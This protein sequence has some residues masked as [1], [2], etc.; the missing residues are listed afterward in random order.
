MKE[1]R[2]ALPPEFDEGLATRLIPSQALAPES[3]P[4]SH[5]TDIR[6]V[7]ATHYFLPVSNRVPLKFAREVV[8]RVNCARV[9]LRLRDRQGREAE[10]WGETPL[11]VT[12]VWPSS[13][14]FEACERA[15]IALTRLLAE[16]W[17]RF[18]VTGDAIEVGYAFQRQVLPDL[19]EAHIYI[20][21][22]NTQL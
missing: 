14:T 1:S 4:M 22:Q 7:A 19:L 15:M 20:Q 2:S 17:A 10:G 9:C 6:P 18:E 13:L 5:S 16:R 3:S 8:N 12:W 11:S 21:L